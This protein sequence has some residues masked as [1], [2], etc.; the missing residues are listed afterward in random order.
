MGAWRQAGPGP[1]GTD[2]GEVN[3]RPSRLLADHIELAGAG[4]AGVAAGSETMTVQALRL[5][6]IDRLRVELEK[7]TGK[8]VVL[9]TVDRPGPRERPGDAGSGPAAG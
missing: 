2:R 8:P 4:E 6:E 1:D 3:H 7:L 5:G 9:N